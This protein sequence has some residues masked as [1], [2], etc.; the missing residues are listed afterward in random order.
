[1]NTHGNRAANTHTWQCY[2][3]GC[4]RP[5]CRKAWRQYQAD[6]NRAIA[7]GRHTPEPLVDVD[8]ARRR[9][10]QLRMIGLGTR[11]IASLAGLERSIVDRIAY[12]QQDHA[13]RATVKAISDIV[14]D[15]TRLPHRARIDG[16]GTRRRIQ[17]L[18]AIG[19]TFEDLAARAGCTSSNLRQ[20]ANGHPCRP[21]AASSWLL[22][23]RLYNRLW[24]E[25]PTDDRWSRASRRMARER[26]WA[27][28][29][30]WDD[31]QI[32]NPAAEPAGIAKEAA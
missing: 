7:Y 26:G 18:I 9:I 1:M 2:S 10:A 11:A 30:A 3:A 5:E 25:I 15:P 12:G 16:T 23:H 14:I 27:P 29:L 20:I 21:V 6:R 31:D 13:T 24:N 22:A 8:L 19:W 4:R 32:D 28:P 17:A